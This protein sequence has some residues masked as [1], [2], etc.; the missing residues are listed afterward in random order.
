[1]KTFTEWLDNDAEE[2][3]ICFSPPMDSQLA[4]DFLQRYL[5]GEDWYSMVPQSQDQINTEIV[6][7]ILLKYSPKFRKEFRKYIKQQKKR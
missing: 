6:Y 3:G 2:C 4:V 5:L 7:Y 1:M